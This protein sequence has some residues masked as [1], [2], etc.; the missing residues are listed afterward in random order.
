MRTSK[1]VVTS[2]VVIVLIGVFAALP[3][4]MPPSMLEKMPS[5]FRHQVTLGL[6]L[7]GGSHLVLEVDANALKTDRL[8]S[9]LDDARG[10]LRKERIPV[11]SAR[12][13][14]DAVVIS[15]DDDNQRA[16]ALDVLKKLAD[17]GHGIGFGA[18]TADIDVTSTDEADQAER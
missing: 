12:V 5:W 18:G 3:S 11:Q 15:I 4:A 13:A 7:Q 6:D 2:Y 10:A 8:R 16:Q 9:L 17:A 1:W 14:G